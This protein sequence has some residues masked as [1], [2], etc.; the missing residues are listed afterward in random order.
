MGTV[1]AKTG[2]LVGGDE[3]DDDYNHCILPLT[4]GRQLGRPPL[5]RKESQTQGTRFRR[6]SKCG[7]VGHTRR[8]CRNPRADF[9]ANYEGDIMEVEDLLDGSYVP[10]R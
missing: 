2:Q 5:K 1:D 7:K 10:G 8:T 3:L 6:C 4:N 9:D